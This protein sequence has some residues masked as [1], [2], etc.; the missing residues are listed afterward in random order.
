MPHDL[1]ERSEK[2]PGEARF[3]F[4]SRIVSKKNLISA[5]NYFKNV[6][7]KASFDVYGPKED[8]AYWHECEH[9]I[10]QLP[11]NVK[12]T[13]KGVLAHDEIHR[14]FCLYDAFLFPTFSENYG[15]VIAEALVTG[16]IPVISDQTPWTDMNEA[17]AGWAISLKDSKAFSAALQQVVDMSENVINQKRQRIEKYLQKK[18]RIKELRNEYLDAF[19]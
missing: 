12:V 11:S 13:Y 19:Q 14:T 1:P 15:H 6:K 7:G 3:V 16:C 9:A 8:E 17:E 5:I 10:A 18:L 4:I 2:H